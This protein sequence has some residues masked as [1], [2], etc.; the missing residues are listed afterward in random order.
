MV[1]RRVED[2]VS[3]AGGSRPVRTESGTE[4]APGD[5]DR[6]IDWLQS[7]LTV[8][9]IRETRLVSVQVEHRDPRVAREIADT[10]VQMFVE[11]QKRSRS[12][13]DNDRVESL[14]AQVAE[15]SSD[16]EALESKLYNSRQAGLSVLE[17]RLKQLTETSGGLIDT[18]IKSKIERAASG[19]RLA[20]VETKLDAILTRLDKVETAWRVK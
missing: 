5:L 18:Y 10:A 6:E 9:P 8:K 20:R 16:I 19:E 4:V 15:V 12:R 7:L 3:S 13:V 17:S 2:W 1:A 14:K 11:Y